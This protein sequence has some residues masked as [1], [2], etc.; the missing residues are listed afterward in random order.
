MRQY[1]LLKVS[2]QYPNS[3]LEYRYLTFCKFLLQLISNVEG[4]ATLP[5]YTSPTTK[6]TMMMIG[7]DQSQRRT[8]NTFSSPSEALRRRRQRFP[9][10]LQRKKERLVSLRCK[11][12]TFF[13]P[14]I[15]EFFRACSIPYT[16]YQTLTVHKGVEKLS[17]KSPTN[18]MFFHKTNDYLET[19]ALLY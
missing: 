16:V 10:H 9:L 8:R 18:S 13:P 15:I 12:H 6:M 7:R 11:P 19:S 4:M 3:Q 17:Y 14:K 1:S 5:N 2:M